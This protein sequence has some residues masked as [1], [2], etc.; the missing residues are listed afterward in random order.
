M[1]KETWQESNSFK[2]NCCQLWQL[3]VSSV[4][5]TYKHVASYHP[6]D[7]STYHV[8]LTTNVEV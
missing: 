5:V 2:K 1:T 7:G 4:E 8:L 6:Q 3:S